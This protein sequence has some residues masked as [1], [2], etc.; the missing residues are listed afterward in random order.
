MAR[1]LNRRQLQIVAGRAVQLYLE[2]SAGLRTAR[3]MD[4]F[5]TPDVREWVRTQ[6][7]KETRGQASL[8]KIALHPPRTDGRVDVTALV[9]HRDRL[10]SVVTL[11]L[12]PVGD[13]WQICELDHLRRGQWREAP[14]PIDPSEDRPRNPSSPAIDIAVLRGAAVQS[15]EAATRAGHPAEAERLTAT[16]AHYRQRALEL[17]REAGLAPSDRPAGRASDIERHAT[18]LL[19]SR[20]RS[21]QGA[22]IWMEGV[23]I[24]ADYRERWRVSDDKRALG[25]L[26]S[27]QP[28]HAARRVAFT[29]LS[30]VLRRVSQLEARGPQEHGVELG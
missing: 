17:A 11:Q 2:V 26:P 7:G 12:Q 20:P 1:R 5:S 28:Q 10:V 21:T 6:F 24:V 16:A 30:E 4:R 27:T 23:R 9:R 19:G 29:Q 15:A 8:E 14:E 13:R 18:S 3:T 22:A 25:G